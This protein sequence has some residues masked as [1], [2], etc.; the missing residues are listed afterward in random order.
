MLTLKLALEI[1]KKKIPSNHTLIGSYGE[2][3]DKYVFTTRDKNGMIPPGGGHWTVH[4]ETGECKFEYL[5]RETK[6][7]GVGFP[8]APIKEYK[9]IELTE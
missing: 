1:V 7:G 4:K 2:V 5:E 6:K 8:Y 3:K 9:K